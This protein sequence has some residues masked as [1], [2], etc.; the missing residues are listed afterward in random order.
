M[1]KKIISEL[2]F[3][4][5]TENL[6]FIKIIYNGEVIYDDMTGEETLEHLNEVLDTYENKC[7]YEMN[8][9]VVEF[10]HCILTIKGEG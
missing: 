10:H 1:K 2:T 5:L 6:A 4:E 7:I 9:K 8:I 3:R